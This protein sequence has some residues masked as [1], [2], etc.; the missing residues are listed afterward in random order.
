VN[1]TDSTIPAAARCTAGEEVGVAAGTVRTT[2]SSAHFREDEI[3]KI[4]EYR[5]R[6]AGRQEKQR[7]K[8]LHLNPLSQ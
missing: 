3:K 5:R 8:R 6:C 1:S 7:G 4:R 2:Y